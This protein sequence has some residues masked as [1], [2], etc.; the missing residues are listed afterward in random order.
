MIGPSPSVRVR[1]SP[2]QP[3]AALATPSLRHRDARGSLHQLVTVRPVPM[4]LGSEPASKPVRVTNRHRHR[5]AAG[6][7]RSG[8]GPPG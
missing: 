7:E 6:A 1:R 3:E 8:P 5:H 4:T 2:R